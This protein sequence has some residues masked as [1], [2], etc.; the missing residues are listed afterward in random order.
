MKKRNKNILIVSI[1][2]ILISFIAIVATYFYTENEIKKVEEAAIEKKK[3]ELI[4]EYEA[5]NQ[6]IGI[7]SCFLGTVNNENEW[8]SA[9]EYVLDL[10]DNYSFKLGDSIKVNINKSEFT[11]DD[12]IENKDFYIYDENKFLG[13]KDDAFYDKDLNP[14]Y[15]YDINTFRFNS[16][17]YFENTDSEENV[18]DNVI[19]D[20]FENYFNFELSKSI[21]KYYASRL[22]EV[23]KDKYSEYEKYVKEVLDKK[24][25]KIDIKINKVIYAD[26]DSNGVN[27]IYILSNSVHK[28]VDDDFKNGRYSLV[29][30]VEN[31]EVE[32]LLEKVLTPETMASMEYYLKYY[33]ISGLTLVDFNNDGKLEIVIEACTWDIPETYVIR[34]N[35]SNEKELCLYGCFAW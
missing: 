17:K 2:I 8:K 22:T 24:G 12:I 35:D 29:L 13:K 26:S 18:E 20:N 10:N 6:Y 3:Q 30:K 25:L 16:Y 23:S 4:A 11:A 19:E 32:I 1:S 9:N 34:L 33:D 5:K 28:D 31:E 14:E 27:E 15:Y 21:D 7:N